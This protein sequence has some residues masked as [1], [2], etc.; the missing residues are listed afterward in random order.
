MSESGAILDFWLTEIGPSGW[1]R[2]D[3]EVDAEIRARFQPA[4]EDARAGHRDFW[5]NGP[6]GTLAFLIL[7]DQFPRN[8]FR[9]DPR[10]FATDARARAAAEAAIAHGWDMEVAEPAR[11]FFYLPMVHSE[12]MADQDRAIALFTSSMPETGASN[13]THARAHREII[14][15]FGRFPF[16]NEALGRDTTK[17]EAAFLD[18]GGYG[19]ILRELEKQG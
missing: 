12:E 19:A 9:G 11:Q 16:R 3:D 15:R 4:W 6:R 1:Y 13:L 5:L 17:E 7:T 18:A 14:R 2:A 10:S 8:M